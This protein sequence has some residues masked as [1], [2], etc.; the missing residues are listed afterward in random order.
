[1]AAIDRFEEK[2]M[3]CKCG[4]GSFVIYH[5]E[6]AHDYVKDHQVWYEGSILCDECSKKYELNTGYNKR[7]I[8]L[9]TKL[10]S[11][12]ECLFDKSF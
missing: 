10:S 9:K 8:Y 7:S 11:N 2:A 3:P 1:M 12:S 5:C 4:K 6:P